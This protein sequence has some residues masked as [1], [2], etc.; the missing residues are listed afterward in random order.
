MLLWRGVPT[1][2]HSVSRRERFTSR[3]FLAWEDLSETGH[4]TLKLFIAFPPA[5]GLQPER[6]ALI[7]LC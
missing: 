6:I 5:H 3:Q 7:S 1:K 2:A 4:F